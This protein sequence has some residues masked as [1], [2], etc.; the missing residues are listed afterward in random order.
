VSPQAEELED[1]QIVQMAL[2]RLRPEDQELLRLA[3]W[4]D[5]STADL[6]RV[7]KCSPNAVTVRLHRAHKRFRSAL[8]AVEDE[9]SAHQ[10]GVST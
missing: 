3:E 5:L 10:S 1:R 9:G 8:L 4:E 7:L 6:A 2:A